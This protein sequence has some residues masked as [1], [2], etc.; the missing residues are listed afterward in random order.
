M[1]AR[2]DAENGKYQ[3]AQAELHAASTALSTYGNAG[4]A[5][6]QDAA[7]LRSDID[8]YSKSIAKNHAD[9]GTKIE[10][11]WDQTTNWM[12]PST[13]NRTQSAQK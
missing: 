3:Q 13:A 8:N 4:G 6:S 9:A 1:L 5:H 7:R 12:T 11:W 10:S 2:T